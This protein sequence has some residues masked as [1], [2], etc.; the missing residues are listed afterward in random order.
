MD[1]LAVRLTGR[2]LSERSNAAVLTVLADSELEPW[3]QVRLAGTVIAQ[4]PEV[5]LR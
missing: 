5:S 1:E 4:M 3:R 2:L